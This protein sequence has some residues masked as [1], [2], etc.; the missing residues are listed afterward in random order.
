[1]V[2]VARGRGPISKRPFPLRAQGALSLEQ[3]N[4]ESSVQG[5]TRNSMH[6]KY[7]VSEDMWL[8]ELGKA[9]PSESPEGYG[10]L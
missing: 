2:I 3:S 5:V 9:F 4:P 10:A 6:S 7:L 8:V 1:M